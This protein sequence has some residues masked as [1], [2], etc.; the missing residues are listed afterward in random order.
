MDKQYNPKKIEKKIYES[1]MNKDCFKAKDSKSTYSIV[2]PPPNVTGTLHM[3]HA[4]QHTIIDILIRFN[5][6]LGKSVLWQPGTDHAGI[7]TQLVVE[8]NLQK[9]GITK[10]KIGRDKLIDEIWKWKDKSGDTI[11]KQTKRIGSSADWNRN[12]FTMD[13]GLSEAVSQV[14]IK[15][16]DE[17]I[18]Y[19]GKRLVN[20]DIKLKTAISDLEVSNIE[21][22]GLLYF[23]DYD[24]E[25]INQKITVA[26][27][28]PETLFGDTAICIHP[29]DSRYKNLANKTALVPFIN[30]KIPIIQDESVDKEFGTGCVKITPAH[31]FNDYKTGLNHNLQSINIMNE[32]GTLNEN[33]YKSFV[34]LN[35][36]KSREIIVDELKKQNRINKIKDYQITLPIAERSGV[37]IEPFLTDQWFMKMKGLAKPAIDVVNDSTVKFVPKNW[38]KIYLN[39]LNK[40]DDWCISRQIWWGHR[41]PIWY[42]SKKN[43]YVGTN[44]NEV[45]KKYN[46]NSKI[47]ITQETD[48]LD[49]WFSSALWPFTTLG[50]PEKS[51]E[52]DL[53][54][55]TNVLVTGFDIIFFWV[56]RMVMMGLKFMKKIPFKTIYIHGLVRDSEGRKMSKSL[57]NIIDPI[58]IIDG[59]NLDDLTNKRIDSLI[60]EKQKQD[61][62][63][64]TRDEFPSGIPSYGADALRFCFC[65]LASTGRDINFDLKRIEG[66]RNFCNKLWNASRYVFMTTENLVY[67]PKD[68][69]ES[70]N[71]FDK[72]IIISLDTLITDYKKHCSNYRFDLMASS[73]YS[74]IWNEYCD[75]YLEISKSDKDHS[76]QVL[77]YTLKIILKLC[78]PIIPYITEEIWSDIY[79]RKYTDDELLINSKFPPQQKIF[80]DEKVL[81][82]IDLV[83]DIVNIIRKTKSDLNIHP[84]KELDI[85]LITNNDDKKNILLQ[86]L[87]IISNLSK[88]NKIIWDVN[89]KIIKDCITQSLNDIK[90]LIPIK[91]FIDIKEEKNRLNKIISQLSSNLD[92]VNSKLNN[93]EFIEKAPSNIIQINLQKKEDL[94]KD[95]ESKKDLLKNLSN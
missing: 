86:N 4:F 94:L 62:I 55:P 69:F 95:I 88:I 91:K 31:D 15:L 60:N 90:I 9:K 93:K 8:N 73:L 11:I 92:K 83:K 27:T 42:D 77:I 1:W 66:Y 50:W 61:I 85:Y 68:N 43:I 79:T 30:R 54:Y 57:G 20:W 41:I 7:A 56:A 84:K 49:T 33:V 38:E 10:D 80:K 78:H 67:N 45:R 35:I 81:K 28:R 14:F 5:R 6:M 40:I 76:P 64:K 47:N 87:S 21:K 22:P 89:D 39:W 71:I 34:G 75:W 58:D 19:K 44:E 59:I 48:V 26:T 65:A 17:K 18:I 36:H 29:D 52:L 12:R 51:K 24:I 46:L 16:Y 70:L 82:T 74:F 2:L 53:Y 72:W 23:I 32:D 25:G 13:E 3:G 37:I 63:K